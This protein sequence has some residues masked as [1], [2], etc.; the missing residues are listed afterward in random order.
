MRAILGEYG[1]VIVCAIV[2]LSIFG[3]CFTLKSG[4]V[5]A[6]LPSPTV[7]VKSDDSFNLV[8]DVSKRAYPT[9]TVPKADCKLKIKRT[10]NL[11]NQNTVHVSATNA[12]GNALSY[13][14][15]RIEFPDGTVKE[16]EAAESSAYSVSLSLRCTLL[17]SSFSAFF[18]VCVSVLMSEVAS[19]FFSE[20]PPAQSDKASD[21]THTAD[22]S[23]FLF[24]W[25]F[26]S[27]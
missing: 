19:S 25:V 9:I 20:Q 10:Y 27:F 12:D 11:L 6:S 22:M 1:K 13:S 7:T 16:K 4:S 15:T 14:I 2:I 24:T 26:S 3:Y 8:D 23:L 18:T 21:S 17:I 5:A